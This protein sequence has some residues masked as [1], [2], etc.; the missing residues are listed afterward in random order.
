MLFLLVGTLT[1]RAIRGSPDTRRT[2]EHRGRDHRHWSKKLHAVLTR[3]AC[4]L[5]PEQ[6]GLTLCLCIH[7]AVALPLLI[8]LEA[9]KYLE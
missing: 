1:F 8:P 9:N 5:Q 2:E 4:L 3:T 6:R 7:G